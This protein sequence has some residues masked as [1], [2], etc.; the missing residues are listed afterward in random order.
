MYTT[1]FGLIAATGLRVSDALDLRFYDLR[2]DGVLLI[3]R[4][5]FGKSQLIPL[6]TTMADALDQY[7]DRRRRL[8][9][10]DDHIFLSAGNRRIAASMVNYTFRSVVR[11]AGVAPERTRPYR[12]HDLRHIFATRSLQQCSARR[13][14]VSRHF[15][16]LAT[17]MGHTDIVHTYWYLEATPELMTDIATAAEVLMGGGGMPNDP[18]RS[19]DYALPTRTRAGRAGL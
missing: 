17:Y 2:P 8:A 3:R 6:H 10:T 16:S 15:V 18:D 7:L 13:E 14:S 12:I 1:L 9:V 11:L 19:A 5:K 4:T